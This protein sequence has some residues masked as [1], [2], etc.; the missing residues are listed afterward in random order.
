MQRVQSVKSCENLF[1]DWEVYLCTIFCYRASAVNYNRLKTQFL[2]SLLW[3]FVILSN[4]YKSVTAIQTLS[5]M[6][7]VI[8]P[9]YTEFYMDWIDQRALHL[10]VGLKCKKIPL[11]WNQ[12]EINFSL[13]NSLSNLLCDYSHSYNSGGVMEI[14]R[15]YHRSATVGKNKL[16]FQYK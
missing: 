9:H 7:F 6:A 15:W 11:V 2:S 8:L 13:A 5:R 3:L 14:G 12:Q 16:A 1:M 4:Y 10:H